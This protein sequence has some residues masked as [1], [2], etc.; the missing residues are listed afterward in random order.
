[1]GSR[2]PVLWRR[3][4]AIPQTEEPDGSD[5]IVTS[6]RS[7]GPSILRS[8]P[9][10]VTVPF[11]TKPKPKVRGAQPP[12]QQVGGIDLSGRDAN[13]STPQPKVKY[14]WSYDFTRFFVLII[15]CRANYIPFFIKK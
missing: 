1:M 11:I 2:H 8:I 6:L 5:D 12:I 4:G 7:R 13:H 10:D 9:G 3:L 15:E 14:K